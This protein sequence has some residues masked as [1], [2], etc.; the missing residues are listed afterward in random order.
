[1]DSNNKTKIFY[2]IAQVYFVC[3][4]RDNENASDLYPDAGGYM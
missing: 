1:M 2:K 3:Y 4:S